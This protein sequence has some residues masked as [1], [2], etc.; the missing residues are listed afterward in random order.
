MGDR[1]PL[2]EIRRLDDLFTG[3]PAG[4]LARRLDVRLTL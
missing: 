3:P 1:L 4:R 2:L